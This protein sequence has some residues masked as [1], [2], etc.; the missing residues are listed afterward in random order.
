[1]T[2]H[3]VSSLNELA[4]PEAKI[5]LANLIKPINIM[6]NRP[7]HLCHGTILGE[8]LISSINVPPA[9]TAAVDGYAFRHADL[10]TSKN[11]M[12]RL[13]GKAH[14]GH[15]L[16]HDFMP[17]TTIYIT[18][19]TPMPVAA[20]PLV[21]PD[22]I[23]MQEHCEIIEKDGETWV[24]LPKNIKPNVNYRP[25]GENIRSGE[26]ALTKGIRLG[27]AEIGLAAAIGKK[28]LETM[29]KV[30]VGILSTGEELQDIKM[31]S[32]D[33]SIAAS[34]I[35]DSNRPMLN[36]LLLN[37][38]YQVNDGGIIG[39]ECDSLSQA[40][41]DLISTSDAVI[42]TGGSS[43]GTED[44]A[45]A[46]ITSAGGFVDF[47]GLKI[48]PGR[49]FAAGLINKTPIFCIPGNPV[50][51]YVTYQLLVSDA[52]NR[53]AGGKPRSL[54]RFPVTCGFDVK[55]KPGRTDFIRVT[56]TEQDAKLPLAMPH[57]RFGAGVL[58]SVT[59]ANGLL[60]IAANLGNVKKGDICHFI[61][62]RE[63]L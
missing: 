15:P 32:P 16:A 48:K 10:I 9:D 7:L 54:L 4:L 50:A 53:L 22:T 28:T 46:A 62:F 47:S 43:G 36:S 3:S 31:A 1:M 57:G 29:R 40:M 5:R 59:G 14:A 63:A 45:R 12:L 44:F 49:P 61:P 60:E 13:S 58:T 34:H 26:T 30:N 42:V 2:N 11:N 19:G 41:N 8:D 17:N 27:S 24:K 20:N 35:Y 18:T 37:E 21:N 25:A 52:L 6:E 55:H 56:L 51:V 38:G 39:D 23:A 33:Q